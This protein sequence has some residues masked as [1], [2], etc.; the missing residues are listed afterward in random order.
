MDISIHLGPIPADQAPAR[1]NGR[2]RFESAQALSMRRGRSMS[3]EAE[4]A[5]EDVSRLRDDV[6]RG[7]SA[8]FIHHSP[9]HCTP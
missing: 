2:V 5:L 3:P 7:R 1:W 4:I 9:S 6:Q 8:S